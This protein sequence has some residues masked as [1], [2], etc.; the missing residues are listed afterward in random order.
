[1]I[2]LARARRNRVDRR[3]MAERLVLG[4]ERGGDVLRDHEPGVQASIRRQEC[5]QPIAQIRIDEALDAPLRDVRKLGN[6]H[7]E[8]IERESEWLAMEIPRRYQHLLVHEH[9]RVVGRRIQLGRHRVVDVI[10]QITRSTVHL[11]RAAKR[12]RVL[13]LVAPAVGLADRGALE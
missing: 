4:D 8:R 7:C 6:G 12:V 5:R 9:E 13:N 11:R 3:R 10:E 2:L 1:M